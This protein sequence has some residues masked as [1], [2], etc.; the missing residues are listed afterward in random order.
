MNFHPVLVH[1]P[2][3]LLSI[4]ALMEIVRLKRFTLNKAYQDIK[5]FLAIIGTASAWAASWTGDDARAAFRGK[6]LVE[7]VVHTH[8]NYADLTIAIFS[9]IAGAYL[10]IF[11]SRWLGKVR[12]W[13]ILEKIAAFILRPSIV[14]T[15]AIVGIILLTITGALGGLMVYGVNSDPVVAFVAHLFFPNL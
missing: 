14:I 1:F 5:A 2:I 3:A 9:L 10:V 12:Y 7:Q 13:N 4:Y 15:L 8:E 6:A 11:L